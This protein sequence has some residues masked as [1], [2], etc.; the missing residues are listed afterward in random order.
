MVKLSFPVTRFRTLL[1]AALVAIAMALF[2][3]LGWIGG[4]T[5]P[6]DVAAIRAAGTW[7]AQH[8]QLTGWII[9]YTHLGSGVALLTMTGL[10]ALW[11]W[12]RRHRARA[13]ALFVTVMGGRLGIEAIKLFVDRPRPSLEAHPV[14]VH[15]QSFPSAHAGNSMLTFLAL[16]VFLA[17]R[18]WRVPAVVAAI[19]AALAMGVTRPLLGV[20]WP[21]DV[22]AGWIYGA[23]LVLLAAMWLKRRDARTGA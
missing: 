20:H 18:R 22:L 11:L 7:R 21:S 17:P 23:T 6:L 1:A 15:S 3:A 2:L 12:Y 10:G 13:V 16:A 14:G 19:T 8:P 4:M 9:L 5:C